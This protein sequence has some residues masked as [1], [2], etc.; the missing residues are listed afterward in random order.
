MSALPA[1]SAAVPVVSAQGVGKR[2][3]PTVALSDVSL[4][5]RPGESHALVGRN[6]AGKSTLVS[7]L[8]G[9][10]KT[11]TG[12]VEFGGVPAPPLYK[13]DDWKRAVAC[14]YQHAM[15]VPQLTV[16]ENLFLN[17][18]SGKGFA[19]GWQRLRR[20]ARELLDS[21]DVHVDVD[22][23]AGELSVEDRQFVEIA[24]ALSHGARFIVLDEPTAQLDSQAIERLFERMRQMQANG[25]TFLFISHHLHEVY[26]VC[27]AVTVLRDAKHILTAPVSEVGRAELIDAMTGEQGGLSVRDAS[28]REALDSDADE[29]LA[30]DGLSGD[31]FTDVTFRIH[32]GEVLGL[33]GSNASGKHQVAETV[34]G[35]RPV[36][37]G[38]IQVEGKPLKPGDIPA[39]IRAGI[40]CVPRDRH[41]EG[42]VLEH[43]IMDNATLSILDRMGKGG[44]ASPS[45]RY[46][47]GSKALE[48]YDIVA[49]GADQPVSDLSGGNQQ[50]VVLARALA[51][52]P[53]V[54]V[55]INPTA[56]VDVKSKEALLAVVDRVRAEGKAVLIVSDELDDLRLSDRVLV[57]RAGAVAAE[58]RAGWSDGDLVADI[59][60]VER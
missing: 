35:L 5:V 14:V 24:R 23:P 51:G 43:S 16:A 45:A 19:I 10:S 33:A 32:R 55:L 27:Q 28:T 54:V 13:Q 20:Q 31:G 36:S 56:G 52:D 40:G 15:V 3:G 47:R 53:R 60:G 7:I 1:G 25:V 26:E 29:V 41:Q 22:T 8:T 34:Y 17:R 37:S 12:W 18:Q 11:D 38:T 9:L 39:A 46:E 57:L 49:A 44:I 4:T 48:D 6:G 42:L 50:K 2:Y 58:H 59:E 21:W 30:V